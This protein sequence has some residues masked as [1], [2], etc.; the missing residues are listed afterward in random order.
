MLKNYF[1]LLFGKNG[2]KTHIRK[3]SYSIWRSETNTYYSS[4]GCQTEITSSALESHATFIFLVQRARNVEFY[5]N[6]SE[7]QVLRKF[8]QKIVGTKISLLFEI[9]K[10]KILREKIWPHWFNM[11]FL[12]NRIWELFWKHVE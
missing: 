12:K 10:Y 7:L 4:D 5:T 11:A 1:I 6:G 8:I 2:W 3:S 9:L